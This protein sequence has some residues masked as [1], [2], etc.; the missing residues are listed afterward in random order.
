M[1]SIE[2]KLPRSLQAVWCRNCAYSLEGLADGAVCPECGVRQNPA[3]VVLYGWGRGNHEKLS[4]APARR[5]AWQFVIA[6]GFTI[7]LGSQIAGNGTLNL[8][9]LVLLI[10]IFFAFYAMWLLQ[11]RRSNVPGPAQV[12]L[13]SDGCVQFDSVDPPG[14]WTVLFRRF[15]WVFPLAGIIYL[16]AAR[17]RFAPDDWLQR[18]VL[19][20]WFIVWLFWG[21][22]A[23][24]FR[25][26]PVVAEGALTDAWIPFRRRSPWTST[27]RAKISKTAQGR[28]A[29]SSGRLRIHRSIWRRR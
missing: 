26:K 16:L 25:R 10:V 18:W 11:R 1:N 22:A 20:A 14:A 2:S 5:V 9:W 28:I 4:N 15:H 6:L 3:E 19:L 13:R 29:S 17:Q 24:I 23:A 27:R 8:R 7:S 12:R 21:A